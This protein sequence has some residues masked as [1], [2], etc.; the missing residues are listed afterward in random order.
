VRWTR[1]AVRVARLL[2]CPATRADRRCDT[3]ILGTH[4][5][6]ARGRTCWREVYTCTPGTSILVHMVMQS[7]LGRGVQ[8]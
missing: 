2:V 5:P 6:V 3:L 8:H 1:P 7:I 4:P